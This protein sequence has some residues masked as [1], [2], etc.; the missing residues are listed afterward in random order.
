VKAI[1]C[2]PGEPVRV[3]GAYLEVSAEGKPTGAGLW[4]EAGEALPH[5]PRSSKWVKAELSDE[6]ILQV[7]A[8]PSATLTCPDTS[9][10]RPASQDLPTAIAGPRRPV[11]ALMNA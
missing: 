6:V 5:V 8:G 9:A 3:T 10:C 2:N 7:F 11:P 1:I 4:R